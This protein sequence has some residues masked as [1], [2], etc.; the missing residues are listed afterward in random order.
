MCKG[1][2]SLVAAA[3]AAM[4][5]ISD[6][7]AQ[8]V[9]SPPMTH[10]DRSGSITL[11]NQAQTVMAVNNN[12][13]GCFVQNTSAGDEWLSET[14]ATAV[15]GSPSIWLPSG[16]FFTCSPNGVPTVAI[17]IIGATTGQTFSARE[18]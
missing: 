16:A 11:G 5:V 6:A 2:I 3:V 14:T 8:Y 13:H 10:V 1:S 4:A 18:W 15:I 17:S 12:R 9:V 7:Y